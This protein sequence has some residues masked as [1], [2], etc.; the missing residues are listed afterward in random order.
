MPRQARFQQHLVTHELLQGVLPQL[1]VDKFD[2]WLQHAGT[3][4]EVST[5]PV[6]YRAGG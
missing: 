3:E 6:T 4:E 2:F 5:P 1:L